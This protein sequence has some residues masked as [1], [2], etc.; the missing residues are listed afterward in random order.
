[1]LAKTI[2]R[3]FSRQRNPVVAYDPIAWPGKWELLITQ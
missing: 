2:H 1:M 3:S